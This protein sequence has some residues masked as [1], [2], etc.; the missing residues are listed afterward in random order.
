M[1]TVLSIA[2]QI[3]F[4]FCQPLNI[5]VP[6]LLYVFQEFLKYPLQM[7]GTFEIKNGGL[8]IRELERVLGGFREERDENS[9][10]IKNNSNIGVNCDKKTLKVFKY[11]QPD[12]IDSQIFQSLSDSCIMDLLIKSDGVFTPSQLILQFEKLTN[13]LAGYEAF[14][15]RNF[16]EKHFNEVL[17]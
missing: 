12:F 10:I 14:N 2:C 5:S 15:N 13:R 4:R 16:I 8:T 17:Q 9:F 1:E 7:R 6:V 3:R 11:L